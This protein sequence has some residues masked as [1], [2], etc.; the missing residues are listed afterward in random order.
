MENKN[1]GWKRVGREMKIDM[2]FIFR[3]LSG[4]L[5]FVGTRVL[6]V[7]VGLEI[8]AELHAFRDMCTSCPAD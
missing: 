7:A 5:L 2:P 3:E 8:P 1:S 4:D 6:M